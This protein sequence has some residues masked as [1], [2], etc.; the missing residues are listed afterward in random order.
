M[1]LT[2]THPHF[3]IAS[4]CELLMVVVREFLVD[5]YQAHR[6]SQPKSMSQEEITN[7]S[8]SATLGKTKER[9]SAL[10]QVPCKIQRKHARLRIL[11]Q[12]KARS[13]EQAYP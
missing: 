10:R 8:I 11:P 4:L 12:E 6:K 2:L 9:L 13:M 7:Y 3:V 5:G 1:Y